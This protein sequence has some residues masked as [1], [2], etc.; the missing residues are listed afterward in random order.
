MEEQMKDEPF[1]WERE[2]GRRISD[3]IDR[4]ILST[5]AGSTPPG[6]DSPYYEVRSVCKERQDHMR[7]G[8]WSLVPDELESMVKQSPT[9]VYLD[10]DGSQVY[11]G[12]NGSSDDADLVPI[13]WP[14]NWPE[15]V[16]AE[17]LREQGI[18]IL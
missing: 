9:H 11:H 18:A 12:L 6:E 14:E 1:D 2:A 8:N 13:P 4:D 3:A 17:W 16:S 5:A 15:N 10:H 7:R